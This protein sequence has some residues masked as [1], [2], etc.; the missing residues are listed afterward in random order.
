MQNKN[1][2]KNIKNILKYLNKRER[3]DLSSSILKEKETISATFNISATL[4][5]Q[6]FSS[7]QSST[8]IISHLKKKL[9][10]L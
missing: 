2:F 1:A 6:T 9:P 3:S 8:S 5:G 10:A 7:K 4:V